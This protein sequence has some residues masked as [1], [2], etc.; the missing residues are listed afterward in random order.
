MDELTIRRIAMGLIT[1]NT[2]YIADE[3]TDVRTIALAFVSG[4]VTMANEL[5]TTLDAE[6]DANG[7][8]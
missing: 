7:R 8:H 3:D 5:I 2:E 6:G 4:V 1:R